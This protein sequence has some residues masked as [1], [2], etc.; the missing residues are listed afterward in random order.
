MGLRMLIRGMEGPDVRAVQIGLNKVNEGDQDDLEPDGVFGGLTDSAVRRFQEDKRLDVDGIV[1]PS[2]RSALFPLVAV[3]VNVVGLRTQSD[4]APSRL[5]QRIQ[6]AF[7]PGR[8]T[9]G[10]ITPANSSGLSLTLPPLFAMPRTL[11]DEMVSYN[12]LPDMVPTPRTVASGRG[13]IEVDWQQIAQ[14]Q[15]Q[16]TGLFRNPQDSFAIGIQSVF[17]R[18]NDD[19]H[20]EIATGCLLQSPIGISGP[21]GNDFTIACFANATWVD[22][23]GAGAVPSLVALLPGAVPRQPD[24]SSERDQPDKPFSDQHERRPERRRSPAQRKR[25][26]RVEPAVHAQR[27]GLD[28][29]PIG[30]PGTHRQISGL[31]THYRLR[32]PN[33]QVRAVGRP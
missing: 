6:D 16:F 10:G 4:S 33:F 20:I 32:R 27:P 13:R 18:N 14:T 21:G 12:G 28:L 3:S 11:S 30:R 1:G 8:L 23:L 29:G 25:R 5:Q 22:P 7:S 19:G 17:K 15:R 24:G 9:L 31:L 2:T 26:G